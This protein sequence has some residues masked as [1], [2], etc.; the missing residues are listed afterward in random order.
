[1]NGVTYEQSDIKKCFALPL[2]FDH[3]G[4]PHS[5]VHDATYEEDEFFSRFAIFAE[6]LR[7]VKEHN[8]K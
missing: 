5:Q 3:G 4:E 8:A 6:N 7:K 1:M 2:L